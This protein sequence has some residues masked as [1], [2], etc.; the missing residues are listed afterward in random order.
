MKNG[1]T[2]ITSISK[3]NKMSIGIQVGAN[4]DAILAAE[5][6]I[7]TILNTPAGDSVRIEALQAFT[8]VCNVNG[9]IIQNCVVSGFTQRKKKKK[10]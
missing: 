3:E 10:K 5:K 7:M 9:A 2:N 1:Q 6:A 8:K 4:K